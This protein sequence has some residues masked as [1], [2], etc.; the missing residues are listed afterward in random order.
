M[1]SATLGFAGPTALAAM[2]FAAYETS[3]MPEEIAPWLEK[4]MACALVVVLAVVH[5]STRRNSGGLQVVFT[6][7]KVLII[8]AFCALTLL[9]VGEAQ[10]V[11]FT[12]VSGDGALL[13][14][15]PSSC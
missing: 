14:R 12:P 2:T 11:T 5:A 13:S 8:V 6:I 15:C 4:T 1:T 9:L 10:P 7:L 3:V